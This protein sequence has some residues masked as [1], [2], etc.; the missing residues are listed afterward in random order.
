M[1]R[2]YPLIDIQFSKCM[3]K[4]Q[5]SPK[6]IVEE[7]RKQCKYLRVKLTIYKKNGK[8][9]ENN[10]PAN[11]SE[12]KM[13][14]TEWQ[15]PSAFGAFALGLTLLYFMNYSNIKKSIVNEYKQ[16]DKKKGSFAT[17][18]PPVL[19]PRKQ[20]G[21]FK[22]P[23][24]LKMGP[25]YVQIKSTQGRIKVGDRIVAAT[26]TVGRPHP[27]D[28]TILITQLMW[29]NPLR[30]VTQTGWRD[31]LNHLVYTG[32]MINKSG[33]PIASYFND[34]RQWRF[35]TTGS[36]HFLQSATITPCK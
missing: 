7:F 34:I 25:P 14:R 11:S 18:K 6:A 10:S 36:G 33:K 30:N 13:K 35:A 23:H 2:C 29:S 28:P 4:G 21:W 15:I 16:A 26:L 20:C 27:L 17:P 9:K 12:V 5:F 24:Q 31:Q 22:Q 1:F 32:V 8:Y 19:K 3:K